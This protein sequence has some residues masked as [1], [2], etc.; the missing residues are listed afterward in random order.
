MASTTGSGAVD[1]VVLWAIIG[2]IAIGTFILRLSFIE[3]FSRLG[4]MPTD[5]E[6][7]LRFVP[8]AVLA[9]LAAPALLFADGGL[10]VAPGNDR[11]VAGLLAGLVAWRTG[12]VLASIAVGMVAIW[13]LTAL[14]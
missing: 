14:F 8:P 9:A 5:T 13:T 6:R 1:P 3:T 7:I 12:S 11:L 2:G 10:A 4:S